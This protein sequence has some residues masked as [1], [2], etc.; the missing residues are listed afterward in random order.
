VWTARRRERTG[1][2]GGRPRAHDRRPPYPGYPPDYPPYAVEARKVSRWHG[3][4]T[5]DNMLTWQGTGGFSVDASVR[6]HG[7]DRAGRER[8]IRYCARPPFALDRLRI[9]REPGARRRLAGAGNTESSGTR[10]TPR[11]APESRGGEGEAPPRV[12][13]GRGPA[14]RRRG[15]R[16][17][18]GD[19]RQG[20][21]RRRGRRAVP[22]GG[23]RG[24]G[25]V[26]GRGAVLGWR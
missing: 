15:G 12:A 18:P 19:R 7:S 3:R 1:T 4:R 20:R 22:R 8:L 10:S 13:A 25:E 6:I 2:A 24:P 14:V 16:P 26:W 9:E 23:R 11:T 5:I 17:R 21:S